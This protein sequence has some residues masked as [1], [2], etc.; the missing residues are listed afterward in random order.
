M[1][2]EKNKYTCEKCPGITIYGQLQEKIQ[3]P[4]T[5]FKRTEASELLRLLKEA[6]E[7]IKEIE[8]PH[9]AKYKGELG[10]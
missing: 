2:H 4:C 10:D 5:V 1:H 3:S 9:K 6:H 7:P 8:P